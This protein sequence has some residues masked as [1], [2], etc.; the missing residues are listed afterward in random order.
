MDF[1]IGL[2]DV[3]IAVLQ[4]L[5][6]RVT[7]QAMD[8]V[9]ETRDGMLE[10]DGFQEFSRSISELN[11]LLQALDA[12][13]IEAAMGSEPTKVALETLNSQLRIA[14]K[15]IKDYKS[16]SR[17]RLLLHSNSVF[18]QM[19]TL[20]EEIAK[21]ISSLQLVNLD[22]T[23]NLK[24]KTNEI[25]N[26][27]RSI[28]FRSAA[29]TETIASEIEK[30]ITQDSRNQENAQ[31]LLQK[32]AEA[33]G[34]SVNASLVQNE[35]ALLKQEKEEMEAQKKQAEALQLS[36]LI[37]LLHSTE[38]GMS[39]QDEEIASYHQQYPIESFICPLCNKMMV[40]PVAIVCG[41]SFERKAIEEQFGRGE[42]TCPIC[43]QELP[44]MEI[45]PNL[46][47]RSSIEE[48]KQRDMDLKF[49]AAVRGINSNDHSLQ[50]KALEDMQVLM[51]MPRYTEK[52]A[53][54]GLISKLVQI[55]KDKR[56]N[57]MASLKCLYYL[58]KYCDNHKEAIVNAGAIRCIVKQFCKGEAEPDALAVLLELSVKETL[59]EKI[60]NTKD[61]ILFLVSLLNNKNQEV[62]QKAQKVLQ[63]LSSS[64]HFVVKM[65]EA[66]HFQP[67]VPRFN[68][69]PQE[70]RALMSAALI[71]MQLKESTI[72]ELN[73]KQFIHN[74][75][76][77]LSS[78]SPACKTASLKAIKKLIA[79]P[80]M[81]KQLLEDPA[82]IPRLLSLISFVRSDPQWKQEAVEILALL[83]GATQFSELQ[84]YHSLQELQS[85]HNVS[86]FWQLIASSD[87][88]MKVH[89]LHLLTE[90][91]YK[92]ETV[93]ILIRSD[94][95][96]VT[97]LFSSLD[98][99]RPMV[100]RWA[101]KLIYR[102]SEGHPAGVPL[103][104]SPAKEAAINTLA[105]IFT[106]SPD[107]EER[108]TA[109][110]I[111]SLLP[112]NDIIIDEIL[113]KSEALKAIHEVICSTDE[114]HSGIEA[115]T[116]Q[117]TTLLENAL[118]ALLRYTQPTKPE[119]QKQVGK[120][121]L[122]PSLVRV[123]SRGSSLAKQ[124]TATALAHLSHSTSQLV[125]DATIIA[126]QAKNSRPLLHIMKLF[127]NIS[128]CCSASS[129]NQNLCSVHGAACSSKQTF[130]L[131][132]EDALRP[133]VQT[134]SET[135]SGV[136]E[137]ALTALETLLGDHATL[138]HA[139]AA[140]VDSQGVVALLQV[141]EKGSSSAKS[142]ALDL[143]LKILK[144]TEITDSLSQRSE[145]VLIQLLQDDALKKKV[146]L[147]LKQMK[148]IPEQSS[149]F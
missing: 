105:D 9:S 147:V 119:L 148:I 5:W 92:S 18:L 97:Q 19:Q 132:K 28:E 139:A 104:T 1:N 117:G 36:Q 127:S 17:L 136:V 29:A 79:Y 95:D 96:A 6:N 25:I 61:C 3:G 77:M 52:V 39:P 44:S 131:V 76:Q 56:L 82:T 114:E 65:A 138:S 26:N 12:K 129:E 107:T 106:N 102:I 81:A 89:F 43:K 125:S 34:L 109:A 103:P 73:N 116:E 13:K 118:A 101:M 93:R 122:Y 40:D 71:N 134:L 59:V 15:V 67:Y 57:N 49:Q 83:V 42:R 100:R 112:I 20:S 108:S 94:E 53:E 22:I 137:A 126:N 70:T 14:C 130:C 64:T 21:T 88:Q 99:D 32:I 120:L 141:L 91:S 50:N 128:W 84:I 27:L 113:C 63:N 10:K 140:I 54:K 30:S 123:L 51:E 41:H 115:P 31:R 133:L 7:F 87:S 35:L 90:L 144:H 75:V 23:L 66:G 69:G 80:E 47:L 46:L 86:L 11:I 24:S 146:A 2:Q 98:G 124:R 45:T 8:L 38:I 48:W 55:L 4:E 135:E 78:S 85:Q 145:R 143:F 110:G 149:Y 33:I 142:P 72:K 68:Q 121:E 58:A 62:S 37:Q 111:I 60:G 16:G 74:L